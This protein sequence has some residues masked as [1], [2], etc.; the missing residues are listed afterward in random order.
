ML[1]SKLPYWMHKARILSKS[2]YLDP[3]IVT[4]WPPAKMVPQH[5]SILIKYQSNDW[6]AFTATFKWKFKWNNIQ[7]LG[8]QFVSL[9]INLRDVNIVGYNKSKILQQSIEMRL[10]L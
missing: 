2:N 5:Q 8:K 1:K 6:T 3:K 4:N 10:W 9:T 7:I